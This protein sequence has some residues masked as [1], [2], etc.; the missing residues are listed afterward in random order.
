MSNKKLKAVN[1]FIFAGSFSVGT[2]EAG[3]ELEK[4]LEISDDILEKNAFYFKKNYP[5]IPVILPSEWENDTYLAA[6]KNENVDIMCCNCPCSGLSRI[7]LK[8]SADQPQNQHFYRLFNIFEKA[9]PKTFVVENA[10][11]LPSMGYP[12][13]KNMFNQLSK[14]YRFTI[15]HDAAGNH[16]VAMVRK[17]TMIVGWRRD[18]FDK[19]PLIDPARQPKLGAGKV[20]EKPFSIK[21]TEIPDSSYNQIKGLLKYAMPNNSILNS[22]AKHVIN[23]D[24]C[25]DEILNG[26]KGTSV[27]H[28][29][30]HVKNAIEKNIGCFDKSPWKPAPDHTF[31]SFATPQGHMHPTEDRFLTANEMGRVMGFPDWFDW[32]DDNKECKIWVRQAICQGVPANFGKWIC[33]NVKNALENKCSYV[34]DG[35]I[36]FQNNNHM[37]ISEYSLD[38]ANEIT[39]MKD[40]GKGVAWKINED[41]TLS[42]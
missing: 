32:S 15:I 12:I 14:L 39:E 30:Y 24:P 7:N 42:K 20:L 8:A 40:K 18:I 26:I 36:V 33:E 35:D 3:F 27:E 23:N 34:T 25:K 9:Q 28:G 31:K 29:F 16:N 13:L 2:M 19:I 5:K 37:L 41:L 10:P 21:Q 11:T 17:R 22:L 1:A 6:L 38:E 4:V